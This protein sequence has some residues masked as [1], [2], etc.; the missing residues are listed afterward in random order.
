MLTSKITPEREAAYRALRVC[1]WEASAKA[2]RDGTARLAGVAQ[3]LLED[4]GDN[5]DDC[6]NEYTAL[7]AIK[8]LQ[9]SEQRT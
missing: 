4:I 7:L 5:P 9:K 1:G 6:D 2:V 3:E 8:A